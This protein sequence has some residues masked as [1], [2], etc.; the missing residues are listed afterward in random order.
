[1]AMDDDPTL[2]LKAWAAVIFGGMGVGMLMVAVGVKV[3]EKLGLVEAVDR[4]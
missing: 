4:D 1:M 2:A 3:L